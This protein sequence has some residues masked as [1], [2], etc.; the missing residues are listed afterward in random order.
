MEPIYYPFFYFIEIGCLNEILSFI[1]IKCHL[2][3]IL[4]NNIYILFESLIIALFF[5]KIGLFKRSKFLY[6]CIALSF[7]LFWIFQ[8]LQL[9]KFENFYLYFRIYYSIIIVFM[10]IS[11]INNLLIVETKNLLRNA[12]FIICTGFVIYFTYCAIIYTFWLYGLSKTDEFRILI[13]KIL[14]YVNLFCNLIYA[15]ALIWIPRHRPSIL[16]SSLPA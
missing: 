6:T 1:L 10:S 12:N 8:M 15:F 5:K 9:R 16:L 3:T 11:T 2:H 14:A 4:N 13:V 7:I